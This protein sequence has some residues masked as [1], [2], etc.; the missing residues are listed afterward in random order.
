M[1]QTQSETR[2]P[3]GR[4]VVVLPTYD[5]R[6]NIV[7]LTQ[8]IL[9]QQQYIENFELIVLISDGDSKDGTI[10]LGE[11]LMA[12]HDNVYFTNIERRG[13]GAA[14][15]LGFKHA[16]EELDADVLIEM[17]SD[18]Q[19]NPDD[20]PHLL[21]PIADG[22]DVVVGSRF[23][24]DS[25]NNMPAYRRLLSVGANNVLRTALGLK[26]ITEITTSFR[27]IR[28][29]TFLLLDEDDVPWWEPKSFIAVPVFLVRLLEKGAKA[30]EVR[31][32]MH[33]RVHG[34]SKMVYWR[35]IQ[36]VLWFSLK[37]RLGL[38]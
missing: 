21:A 16:I 34:Y 11:T 37:N 29:E 13:I 3:L 32:T 5:E 22:Y 30:T 18:F 23:L 24:P 25:E 12:E 8:A 1:T 36:D 33:P 14:L 4:A 6:E 26:D 2:Y 27:A 10:E 9:R 17:D 38:A 28:K 19:H 31:M 35:Y 20:V 15:Y 7:E